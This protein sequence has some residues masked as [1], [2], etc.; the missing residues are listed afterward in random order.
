VTPASN[1]AD[2]PAI[3][4]FERLYRRIKSEFLVPG[5]GERMRA[6]SAAFKSYEMSVLLELLNQQC[7]NDC[8]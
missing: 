3:P 1:H 4:D 8:R 7:A 6:A 5:D 2:D